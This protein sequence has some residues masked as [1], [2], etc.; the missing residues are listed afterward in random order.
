MLNLLKSNDTLCLDDKKTAEKGDMN[1]SC[2]RSSTE[3]RLP[4]V[5]F[6]GLNNIERKNKQDLEDMKNALALLYRKR[7]ELVMCF[8]FNKR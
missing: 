3:N 2:N 8:R 1:I 5:R 4:L 6:E 7:Q